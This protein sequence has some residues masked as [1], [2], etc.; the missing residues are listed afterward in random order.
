MDTYRRRMDAI[1]AGDT[2]LIET[3]DMEFQVR[4]V[5]I[6]STESCAGSLE[7]LSNPEPR[8]GSTIYCLRFAGGGALRGHAGSMIDL[9]FN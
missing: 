3:S 6:V 4:T 7:N 8:K 9:V 5:E 1:R 2:V